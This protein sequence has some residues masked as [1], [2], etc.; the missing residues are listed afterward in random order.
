MLSTLA[1]YASSDRK[2]RLAGESYRYVEQSI[3]LSVKTVTTV[4][5]ESESPRHSRCCDKG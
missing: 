3:A 5:D 4:L 1:S 2:T